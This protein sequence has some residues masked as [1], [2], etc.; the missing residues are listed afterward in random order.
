MQDLM[1]RPPLLAQGSFHPSSGVGCIMNLMCWTKRVNPDEV[2]DQ[3]EGYHPHFQQLLISLND[4]MCAHLRPHQLPPD[5]GEDVVDLNCP[6]CSSLLLDW[7]FALDETEFIDPNIALDN[8]HGFSADGLLSQKEV[9][10]L[11]KLYGKAQ[12]NKKALQNWMGKFIQSYDV[13][14][15]KAVIGTFDYR[16]R[17]H[18]AELLDLPNDYCNKEFENGSKH[19]YE[20]QC[21]CAPELIIAEVVKT[22][23][24]GNHWRSYEARKRKLVG[25]MY[26]LCDYVTTLRDKHAPKA[27]HATK[28]EFTAKLP[29]VLKEYKITVPAS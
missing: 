3:P 6:Q 16:A 12:E 10:K 26:E 15:L 29:T 23:Y 18:L 21:W 22:A 4:G 8:S 25:A 28:D 11:R 9:D 1:Y 7:A 13:D 19:G 17:G 5:Q 20:C 14:G 27:V 24:N 2:N